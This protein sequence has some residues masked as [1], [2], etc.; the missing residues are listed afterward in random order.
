MATTLISPAQCRM[1]RALL[2]W[3]QPELAERCGLATMTI[4]KFEKDETSTRPEARTLERITSVFEVSGVKFTEAGGAEPRDNLVTILEGED[5]NYRV[6]DDIY[7]SLKGKKNAEVLIAGL[8][9]VDKNKDKAKYDFL[10]NHLKRL[11]EAGITERMLIQEGDTNFVAPVEWYR[12]LPKD[13]FTNTP[14]QIYGNRIVMKEW[15]DTQRMVIIEHERF[16]ATLRNL[17]DLV[18][19]QAKPVGKE[20]KK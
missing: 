17:F 16:A 7:H 8:T 10:V 15:G 9:E 12:Y 3:T 4:S 20:H 6:L 13:K 5:V 11:Q 1:A 14:F 2:N 18:W 19:E